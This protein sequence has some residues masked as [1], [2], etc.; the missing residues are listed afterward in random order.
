MNNYNNNFD[1]IPPHVAMMD[2]QLLLTAAAPEDAPMGLPGRYYS[3]RAYFEHE[4][5]TVLRGG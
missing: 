4:C 5:L 2:E 1:D 3:D